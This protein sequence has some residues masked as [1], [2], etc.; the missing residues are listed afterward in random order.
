MRLRVVIVDDEALARQRLR[1]LVGE[2][3]SLELV[4]EAGDGTAA[5][6]LVASA[7][8]DLLFLDVQ[9]P[10]LD[11]FEALASLDPDV[12]PAVVFVTA[13]DEHAVRAFEVGAL[14]YLLKPIVPERFHAAVARLCERLP[15]AD[16]SR[17]ARH[18]A[19]EV[20]RERGFARRLAVRR[21]NTH[22][23]VGTDE[24]R[25]IAADGNYAELHTEGKTHLVRATVKELIGRLD[26][27]RFARI[28][29]STIVAIDSIRSIESSP[30]GEWVVTMED[31][32]PL[33]TSRSYASE[34]RRLRR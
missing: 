13:Y 33:S 5:L 23:F 25:W 24:I 16:Q 17:R 12:T 34:V 2:S 7:V 27:E 22:Y 30:H 1:T 18:A 31:G 21:N 8:P 28:H 26:P 20:E 6:D 9:M 15:L 11:G 3:P 4:G 32:T 14:D 29:R 10:E 19:L